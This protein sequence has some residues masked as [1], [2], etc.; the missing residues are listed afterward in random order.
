MEEDLSPYVVETMVSVP[1]ICQRYKVSPEEVKEAAN[2]NSIQLMKV[3]NGLFK[4][5]TV[6][7]EDKTRLLLESV[8][9]NRSHINGLIK[10]QPLREFFG[11]SFDDFSMFWRTKILPFETMQ[12]DY[13]LLLRGWNCDFT[14]HDSYY[15]LVFTEL[16]KNFSESI[17]KSVKTVTE[18]VTK[19]VAKQKV[20]RKF[21]IGELISLKIKSVCGSKE[22]IK[23]FEVKKCVYTINGNEV[24]ILVV[25][26]FYGPEDRIYTLN[27]HDC[28]KLH[29]K[30]EPGLQ[31]YSM[32]LN[33]GTFKNRNS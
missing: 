5:T 30:F 9:F 12:D 19:A 23:G 10:T 13:Q 25:K 4:R 18:V 21:K 15:K 24:N 14:F 20:K 22:I 8:V 29:I 32:M 33:W 6:F 28:E 26:Q 11:L 27:R 17:G 16:Y 2:R 31:V 1:I 3:R 7:R